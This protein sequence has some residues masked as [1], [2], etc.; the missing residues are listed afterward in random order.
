VLAEELLP[1][2]PGLSQSGQGSLRI[3][4]RHR[5]DAINRNTLMRSRTRAKQTAQLRFTSDGDMMKP[6]ALTNQNSINIQRRLWSL[7]GLRNCAC[8]IAMSASM[9]AVSGCRE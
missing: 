6:L 8:R 7:V 5:K 1:G 4:D 9:E 2:Q 3:P